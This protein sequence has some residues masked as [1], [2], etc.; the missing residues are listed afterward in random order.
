M[1]EGAENF[2]IPSKF[3]KRAARYNVFISMQIKFKK[4]HYLHEK[5]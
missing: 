2:Q 5:T 3:A 1:I 4:I